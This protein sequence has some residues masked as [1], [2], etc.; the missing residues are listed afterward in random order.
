V[1]LLKRIGIILVALV[2]LGAVIG[3]LLPRRIHVERTTS[4]GAPRS[5]VFTLLNS[6]RRFNEWSP[7][8]ALDPAA[9]YTYSGPVSGAGAKMSW[10]GDP[11][12]VGSG[13]QQIV[14]SNPYDSVGARYELGPGM[15][16]DVRFALADEGSATRVTWHFETDLGFNPFS[17]YF[18]LLMERQIAPDFEKGLASLKTLA[19]RMPPVDVSGV[20]VEVGE[21]RS[22]PIAFVAATSGSTEAEIAGA[23]GG[24]LAQVRLF[25]SSNSLTQAGAPRTINT[26]WGGATQSFDVAIPLDRLPSEPVPPESVVKIKGTYAGPVVKAVHKGPYSGMRATYDKVLA[27]ITINGYTPNGDPWDEYVSDPGRVG[28]ADLVTNIYFPVK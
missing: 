16:A 1:K 22:V 20:A 10:V 21:A 13:S 8:A 12:T 23:I 25:M 15:N 7:W 9:Q 3:F 26:N 18:G 24:A 11:R 27:W 17:R 5:T 19:E 4:I 2:V 6:Y 14:A 28:A